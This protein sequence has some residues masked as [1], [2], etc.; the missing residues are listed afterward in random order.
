V[1]KDQ[2]RFVGQTYYSGGAGL[3]GTTADYLRFAQML[4]NGGE[5]DGKR[6]LSRTT[7]DLMMS[8]HTRD[9]GPSAVSPGHGFGYG[10]SVRE[11]LGASPRPTSEGTWGWSGIYGT[12]FWV[13]RK[14]QLVT[15]LMHQMSPRSTR[16]ADVFQS[17]AYASIQ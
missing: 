12:Y 7:V 6:L 2:G 14:E 4:A 15:M 11:S 17:I 10:G 13:D 1:A 3:A 9:L 5:L 16:V 8:S